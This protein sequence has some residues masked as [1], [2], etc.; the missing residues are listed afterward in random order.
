MRIPLPKFD[1]G[2]Q[3]GSQNFFFA[4]PLNEQECKLFYYIPWC[5]HFYCTKEY[6]FKRKSFPYCLLMY[7]QDGKMKV[8]YRGDVFE[9][10]KGDVVLLDCM[11]PHSYSAYD[12]LEF[13][14]IHFDGANAHELCQYY[15]EKNKALIQS[16]RNERIRRFL[17]E[18]VLFYEEDKFESNI[19]T[20]MRVYKSLQLVLKTTVSGDEDRQS[21]IDRT[22]NYIY[23]HIGE[24]L[25]L[26]MLADR[27][28]LNPYYFAHLFKQV[29]GMSLF[30]YIIH[31]RINQAKVLLSGSSQ[32]VADI[33]RAVGYRSGSS[34]TNVFKNRTGYSPSQFRRMTRYEVNDNF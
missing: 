9:A 25:S 17:M 23:N 11:E 34:F 31:S 6:C 27:V 21:V 3:F 12:G 29:T 18:T 2:V 16:K 15:L 30:D 4:W 1:P 28:N 7:I 32:P 22:Q 19:D 20:S 26:K 14:Y 24:K 33:A 8:E 13:Y 5:G 10:L